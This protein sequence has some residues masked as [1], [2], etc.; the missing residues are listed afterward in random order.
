MLWSCYPLSTGFKASLGSGR[1]NET[2]RGRRGGR[3]VYLLLTS[4]RGLL[5]SP[6]PGPPSPSY[7]SRMEILEASLFPLFYP[8]ISILSTH[9]SPFFEIYP[10]PFLSLSHCHHLSLSHHYPGFLRSSPTG[11]PAFV[12]PPFHAFRNRA[13]RVLSPKA[14][15]LL[16][17]AQWFP[18]G[19]IKSIFP[20]VLSKSSTPL[21]Y[22]LG[23]LVPVVPAPP[24][25][26]TTPF[27]YNQTHFLLSSKNA[28][29][30][31]ISVPLQRPL[32]CLEWEYSLLPLCQFSSICSVQLKFPDTPPECS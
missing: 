23:S 32:T 4:S 3:F 7:S 9:L 22:A 12:L 19:L 26:P 6:P 1:G 2:L 8:L 14:T 28:V 18:H 11:L 25:H 13:A 31:P 20:C 29:S 10:S 30:I 27:L 24:P 15:P 17:K 21:T 5:L 16:G